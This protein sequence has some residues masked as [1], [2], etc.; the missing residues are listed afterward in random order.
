MSHAVTHAVTYAITHEDT[1]A[2]TYVVTYAVTDT[3][4]EPRKQFGDIQIIGGRQHPG[5]HLCLVSPK[6]ARFTSDVT[7]SMFFL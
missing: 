6:T 1:Y 7:F 4:L 2:V 3:G 5:M